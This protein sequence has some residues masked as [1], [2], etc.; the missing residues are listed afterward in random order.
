MLTVLPSNKD[1]IN[2]FDYVEDDNLLG[3]IEFIIDGYNLIV[4]NFMVEKYIDNEFLIFDTLIKAC[5]TYAFNHKGFYIYNSCKEIYNL[6][7]K[8]G[9]LEKD[10]KQYITIDKIINHI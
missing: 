5:A 3:Y 6:C 2:R 1:G 7:Q 8:F 4:N 10:N 9:F